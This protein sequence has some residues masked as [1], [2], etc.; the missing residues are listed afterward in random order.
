MAQLMQFLSV[1]IY[2][3]FS[4]YYLKDSTSWSQQ[5]A[6]I[7]QTGADGQSVRAFFA[8]LQEGLL[9]NKFATERKRAV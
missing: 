3:I 1:L 2:T 4:F 8:L 5:T 7:V 9:Q 6:W